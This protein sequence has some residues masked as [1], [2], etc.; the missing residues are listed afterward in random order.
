MFNEIIQMSK[1][2]I[3][4]DVDTYNECKFAMKA[5]ASGN[6]RLTKFLNVLFELIDEKRP[7]LL[8]AH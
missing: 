2:L 5:R 6:K 8:E 1:D 4:M 7:L 3:A